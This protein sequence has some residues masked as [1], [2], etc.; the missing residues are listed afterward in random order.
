MNE[1][2]FPNETPE[3]LSPGAATAYAGIP[4]PD[5][6][7]KRVGL[8]G[9]GAVA[10]AYDVANETFDRFVHRGSQA[11]EDLRRRIDEAR[12]QNMAS[13]SRM[14]GTFRSLMNTFLDGINVPNKADVDVINSKLNI[15]LRKF[16][17]LQMDAVHQ[18]T[19]SAPSTT[20]DVIFPVD[21]T[22]GATGI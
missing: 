10:T 2:P 19:H 17:D 13:R 1:G 12:M 8:A 14:G 4:E 18:A 5:G 6:P 21:E 7:A 22:P 16:D 9:L 15:V 3:G 11:Q 20:P